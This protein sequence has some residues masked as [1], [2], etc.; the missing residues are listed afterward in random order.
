MFL[1]CQTANIAK[2]C[3]VIYCILQFKLIADKFLRDCKKKT[4]A[5]EFH[6]NHV[7]IPLCV[8]SIAKAPAELS[9]AGITLSFLAQL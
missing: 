3:D 4:L 8:L 6:V 5:H 7:Q 1:K 9:K 2:V